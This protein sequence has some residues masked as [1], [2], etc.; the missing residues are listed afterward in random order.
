MSGGTSC[1]VLQ[2]GLAM[3]PSC[4]SRSSGLTWLTTSGMPGSIRQALELSMTVQPRAAACGASSRD[5]P[6][7][8]EK[9]AM[10]TPSKASGVASATSTWRPSNGSVDPA[11]RAEA[12]SRISPIG[13][14]RSSRTV[15]IVRPTTPVAPTT[16]TVRGSG[17]C[18]D[19]APL[20]GRK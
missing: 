17:E 11:E 6:P 1:I 9:R 12:S 19:M 5:V 7:P 8:A 13:K 2:L 14:P 20:S 15:A 4:A 3:I 10:S 16:A 18:P